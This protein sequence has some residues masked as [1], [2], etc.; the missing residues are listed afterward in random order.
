MWWM[1]SGYIMFVLP[2]LVFTLW[3]QFR[4]SS[5][6]EKYG[7]IRSRQGITAEQAARRILDRNGLYHVQIGHVRGNL[8]DYFNPK[9]NTVNLSDSTCFSTSVAA[10]GV[11]AHEVGHAIQYATGYL[12]IKIRNAIVPVVNIASRAAIP[13]FVV[14]LFFNSGFMMDIGILFFTAA[15][16]FQMITLPVELNASRRAVFIV[17]NDYILEKDEVSGAK[18]V[19]TAAAMTYVASAAMSVAQLMRLLSARGRRDG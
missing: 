15:V 19:L 6:Y 17:E 7:K 11:A 18:K 1:D 4:V 12:P 2:A 13:L 14:G 3:A 10:I 9:T 8:T 5:T 16:L